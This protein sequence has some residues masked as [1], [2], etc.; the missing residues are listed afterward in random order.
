M[1]LAG[2]LAIASAEDKKADKTLTEKTVNALET[3]GE[4]A[5]AAGQVVVEKSKQAAG[6]LVDAVT[7]DTDARKVDVKLVDHRID[8]PMT[9]A[10]GKV[11]FVVHNAGKSKHNFKVEGNGVAKNFILD[12]GPND[13]K[14]L[15]VDLKAGDYKVYCPIDDHAAEGM[16][17]KLS[18]K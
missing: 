9:V 6:A 7:P 14:V 13:T 15:H 11:A 1:A 16:K 5:K 8:M 12:L 4:K 10:P 3:A 2:S 17:A 18:V